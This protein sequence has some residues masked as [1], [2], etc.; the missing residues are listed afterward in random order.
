M[1]DLHALYLEVLADAKSVGLEVSS[2]IISVTVNNR[3]SR[4]LGRCIYRRSFCAET[5]ALEFQPNI[6]ADGVETQIAKNV[7]MHEL[8]HTCAG[9]MN[10]GWNFTTRAN[11]VNRTLPGYR[12]EIQSEAAALETAGVVLKRPK[13]AYSIRCRQCGREIERRQR[14]SSTLEDIG[15]CY[16]GSCKRG[17]LYVVKL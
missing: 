13:T 6:L 10:H 7:I 1:K 12:V 16:H 8:I 9:C 11:K 15:S 2:N 3:L 4:A 5:Y 17:M 14:W